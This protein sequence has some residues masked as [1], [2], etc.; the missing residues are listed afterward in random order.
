MDDL[1][2]TKSDF[3]I[4][5]TCPTKLYYRKLGYPS[6][7]ERDGY[8][9]AL[10][11]GGY[12]IGK[13]ARLLYPEGIEIRADGDRGIAQTMEALAAEN[14]TLFE[15]VL[16]SQGKLARVDILVKRGDRFEVIEV[17]SKAF[18]SAENARSLAT[19]GVSLL[20]NKKTGGAS[21]I[22]RSAIED[23]AFQLW[24]LQELWP[25]ATLHPYLLLPDRAKTSAC[26]RLAA[27]FRL[28]RTPEQTVP[29]KFGEVSVEFVGD[30]EA[31][32]ANPLLTLVDVEEEARS[33]LPKIIAEGT[34]Y[35]KS[36]QAPPV[37]LP[38][39]L[40]KTCKT[41]EFRG[42]ATDPRDGFREC[43]GDLADVD[44]HI[45]DLY[46]GGRLGH[47]DRVLI[48]EMIA[49]RRVSLFD[50]A[51][52]A[53]D[54]HAYS[55]RQRVQIHHTRTNTEWFSSELRP[56]LAE[57]RYPLHFIDFETSR[58]AVPYHAGMSPYEQVTF[59]WSCHT[60]AYPGAEPQHADWLDTQSHFP[61]VAFASALMECLGDRGTILTWA[62]HERSVLQDIQRQMTQYG[63]HHD[64]LQAWLEE[65]TRTGKH[66]HGRMV[67]MNDL[68]LKH[69]F[70]PHMKGKTSLKSVLPAVWRANPTLHAL[71]WARPYLHRDDRGNILDPYDTLPSLAIGD[72]AVAIKDGTG[73]MLAYQDM[74]YGQ[75]CDDPTAKGILQALLRQYCKL[76]T[77][78]M[79]LI[80]EHWRDR[81]GL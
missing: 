26:D 29:S 39:K 22:W 58:F 27:Q 48:D 24:V 49:A 75:Y 45:F 4:A 25:Q 3:K 6:T 1:Y 68:T 77:L 44:P 74:L 12:I 76:D 50:V 13:M 43:W 35:L 46:Q 36:L 21:S 17:K 51:P 81:L 80:W 10:Q 69:Y 16:Y 38:A 20:R 37:K 70:H 62:T 47:P 7:A 56:L 52:E 53:I 41:C 23:V 72:R 65:V 71:P 55:Q 11:D 79:V 78:A 2:L 54:G 73:A 30:V 18:D 28:R 61:N 57:V 66:G 5:R 9:R 59:Q 8:T 15:P 64:R 40:S 19:K 34:T 67:D 42:N 60:I 32:R 33:L 31:L 14:V 63:H